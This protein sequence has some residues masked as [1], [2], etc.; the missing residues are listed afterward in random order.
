MFLWK[1]HTETGTHAWLARQSGALAIAQRPLL[2][3]TWKVELFIPSGGS[4]RRSRGQ[5]RIQR[6][7]TGSVADPEGGHGVR[8]VI[9][10]RVSASRWRY[11]PGGGGGEALPYLGVGLLGMCRW[12]GC[13]FEFPA[14]AP[15]LAR[16][17]LSQTMFSRIP[18]LFPSLT[19][20][21]LNFSQNKILK[22]LKIPLEHKIN[23]W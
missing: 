4:R 14:L 3:F 9:R 20:D 1:P 8:D 11:T 17:L 19:A 21:S 13:L 15:A 10:V 5:W 16:F 18:P 6:E 2:L 23:G 7:V 22:S 12:T